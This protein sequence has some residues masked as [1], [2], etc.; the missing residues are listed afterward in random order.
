MKRK[1]SLEEKLAFISLVEQGQSARSVSDRF[2]LG[3]HIL[4]EWL[5]AYKDLGID[6]LKSKEKRPRRTSDYAGIGS[7]YGLAAESNRRE[8]CTRAR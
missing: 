6:G 5:A 1:Y 7:Q 4:F 3:H 8:T 2:H